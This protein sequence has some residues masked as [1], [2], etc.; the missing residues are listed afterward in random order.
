MMEYDVRELDPDDL[1]FLLID[2]VAPRPIAWV[3]TLS[4]EGVINLAPFSFFN[5]V[6][7]QPPVLMLSISKKEDGTKKDTARNILDS[8]E[9]VVN[10]LEMRLLKKARQ[11]AE[12]FPP[13]VSELEV[14]KLTP[15]PSAIVKPPRVKECPASFECRLLEHRELYNYDLILGEVVFIVIRKKRDYR[16]GRVGERFCKCPI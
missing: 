6:C 15:E 9:F 5:V 13:H 11:T 1:Y 2:W 7:D 4:K 8:G 16:V 14:V 3:S 10:F 12:D